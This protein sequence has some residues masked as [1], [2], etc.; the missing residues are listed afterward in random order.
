MV[1]SMNELVER[2][3]PINP[4]D[5]ISI[6]NTAIPVAILVVKSDAEFTVEKANQS[7]FDLIGYAPEEFAELFENKGMRTVHP[8][9][10]VYALPEF[11][12][13][14]HTQDNQSFSIKARLA[15]KQ[16]GY[17]WVNF[18][19]RVGGGEEEQERIYFLL[20]DITEQQETMEK[21]KKETLFYQMVENLCD[22]AFFDCDILSGSIRFS[23]NFAK[24]FCIEEMLPNYPLCLLELGIVAEDSMHFFECGPF[25]EDLGTA[26]EEL[27]MILPGG[28]EV[29]YTCHYKSFFDSIGIPVRTVGKLTEITKQK[30]R[31]EELAEKATKDSLTGLFNKTTTE[32]LIKTSLKVENL[33]GGKSALLI[34]DVDNFK[35]VN[36]RLGHFYG[37]KV[38][39]QM[40]EGLKSF[41]TSEDVVGRIGGDEFFVFLHN[42]GSEALLQKKV[43]KIRGLFR[44]IVHEN[45]E[46]VY[47]SASIGIALCPDHGE[48]FYTLYQNADLALYIAKE[49]GKDSYTIYDGQACMPYQGN[50]TR[51]D[52]RSSALSSEKGNSLDYI[53]R[54]IFSA[55]D[56]N[57]D[58]GEVLRLLGEHYHFSRGYL[59]E[60]EQDKGTIT[61]TFSWCAEGVP[62]AK[63][64]FS[65]AP[66]MLK[67]H[68]AQSL[69][70]TGL[71][72]MHGQE[73][74]SPSEVRKRIAAYGIK[75]MLQ[76]AIKR[77]GELIGFIGFD[78]VE[79][80]RNL[81]EQDL[82]ELGAICFVIGSFVTK[83]RLLEKT[84]KACKQML[85]V[86]DNLSDE[87]YVI[88]GLSYR[89]LYEN[90]AAKV[91]TM[92]PSNEGTLCFQV[93]WG[94]EEPCFNCPIRELHR[95]GNTR[96]IR[97]TESGE[98]VRSEA[99]W[100]P[101]GDEQSAVMLT[102]TCLP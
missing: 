42:Y 2:V 44:K 45:M 12:L 98:R 39:K 40:G 49:Q 64:G 68:I 94:R 6:V 66:K 15:N 61:N 36:D 52:Y 57:R 9:D 41:I 29:W 43:E 51:I 54:R 95:T 38:L 32:V 87:V 22:D 5:D 70:H 102:H 88:D 8:E 28:E 27:H 50:R 10:L 47:I 89:I 90:N 91:R 18:S 67:E 83:Q 82:E 34:V 20:T 100:I 21:L 78:D 93:Y 53:Y 24:R 30:T 31:I 63:E 86:L 77:E 84:G 75:S 76:F 4:L 92:H 74:C 46:I 25:N 17:R 35:E 37:D 1:I 56:I 11:L 71:F 65:R 85:A 3:A 79:H 13:Q 96:F 72:V 55:K 80:E 58:F 19:G 81:S 60:L 62:N 23:K 48:D 101:W 59:F 14:I 97:Q 69:C 73:E 7:F 33:C 26:E 99:K 16:E